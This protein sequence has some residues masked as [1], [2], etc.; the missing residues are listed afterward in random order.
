MKSKLSIAALCCFVSVIC[1]CYGQ[2][3]KADIPVVIDTKKD[4]G[5]GKSRICLSY[6]GIEDTLIVRPYIR[7]DF[8]YPLSDVSKPIVV[9]SVILMG[10]RIYTKEM[11]HIMNLF[12]F[13][14]KG[15][16]KLW[17]LFDA[18]VAVWYRN[19]PYEDI[20]ARPDDISI[21]CGPRIYLAPEK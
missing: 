13:D 4:Y 8:E 21:F 3:R 1:L 5:Q 16:E 9:R 7:V 18:K 17:D 6:P 10:L 12:Y 19:Q 20:A 11:D 2:E 15:N 14:H